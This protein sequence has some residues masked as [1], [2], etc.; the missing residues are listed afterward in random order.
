MIVNDSRLLGTDL[1]VVGRQVET[2]FGG[3]LDVLCIDVS[4]R[5]HALELKRD[6]TPRDVVAQVLDYGSWVSNLT[7]RGPAEH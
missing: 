6:K 4:G 5:L 3:F 7:A 2:A 1:L